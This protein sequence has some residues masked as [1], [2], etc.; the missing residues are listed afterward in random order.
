MKILQSYY[1]IKKLL[2]TNV[3]TGILAMVYLLEGVLEGE[4]YRLL[5][6]N[7]LL[8][9]VKNIK[10]ENLY[11][12]CILKFLVIYLDEKKSVWCV[13]VNN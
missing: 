1:V 8:V 9:Q 6:R 7:H 11:F 4:F 3:M 2:N 5:K 12:W 10:I 13:F